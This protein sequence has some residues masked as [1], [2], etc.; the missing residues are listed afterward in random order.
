MSIF[1]A[2]GIVVENLMQLFIVNNIFIESIILLFVLLCYYSFTPSNYRN[3][4]Y[5]FGLF[6]K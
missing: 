4:R 1:I 2:I 6:N 5:R 3:E